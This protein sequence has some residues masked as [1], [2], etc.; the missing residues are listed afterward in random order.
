MHK[1]RSHLVLGVLGG[2]LEYLSF[3]QHR[4]WLAI[5][6]AAFIFRIATIQ[7]VKAR[8]F[9]VL[10]LQGT[11]FLLYVRWVQAL[12]IDAWLALSTLCV[13]PWLL[14]ALPRFRLKGVTSLIYPAVTVAGI[15]MIRS[16]FPWGGFPWG[17][18]A[19]SQLDG[20]FIGLAQIG[21][22]ALVSAVVVFIG[23]CVFLFVKRFKLRMII[24]PVLL[25]LFASST[26]TKTQSENERGSMYHTEYGGPGNYSGM[27][28]S[29]ITQRI[30]IVQGNAPERV[31]SS[32]S[33]QQEVF[34]THLQLTSQ[35]ASQ[36]V[37]GSST[38]PDLVLW[39][40]NST[41][42]DPLNNETARS[43]LSTVASQIGS[44]ILVGGVTWGGT[45]YGPRNEGV[46]WPVKGPVTQRYAKQHLV[47]FGEY[48]PLRSPLT[49]LISRF[50]QIS[51]DFI[52]GDRPGIFHAGT[53]LFGDLICFEIAY[54]N[55]V[56][57]LIKRGASFITLQTNNATYRG[58]GQADQ[59]F[60]I[61]RFR[62]IEHN[63]DVAVAS[64]TG[65]SGFIDS[66]G[67]VKQKSQ[68]N[69]SMIM[70]DT[71]KMNVYQTFVDRHTHVAD[72]VILLL[73][74][75]SIFADVRRRRRARRI[76]HSLFSK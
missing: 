38:R 55:H 3:V 33:T 17:L 63:R 76:T 7:E 65:F 2:T 35:M 28:G 72:R 47:P 51:T 14:F 46:M 11:F 4:W 44:P 39:P 73:L 53:H 64:T 23:G 62:A 60:T 22:Q 27:D 74:G 30:L 54:D 21:G 31:G 66:T 8:L 41:D 43:Q 24:F 19:Y 12:G 52:P 37:Q 34:A 56:S 67:N 45:P 20:P 40:E 10:A 6:A 50:N 69:K 71:V 42:I 13:S 36:V 61:A 48:L 15:E 18:F 57:T 75:L 58:R 16:S 9:F 26:L 1:W 59:Q 70:T 68:E 25:S 29:S 5:I 32:S 49:K